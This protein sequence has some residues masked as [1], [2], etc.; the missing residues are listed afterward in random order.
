MGSRDTPCHA[1][2]GFGTEL[3]ER[4]VPCLP[5]EVILVG[6][7]PRNRFGSW[8]RGGLAAGGM[9]ATAAGSGLLLLT[10]LR[11]VGILGGTA[12]PHSEHCFSGE[13]HLPEKSQGKQGE[14]CCTMHT[15]MQRV[16]TGARTHTHAAHAQV[17]TEADRA[18]Q[19]CTHGC[20]LW[21]LRMELALWGRRLCQLSCSSSYGKCWGWCCHT[22]VLLCGSIN[23]W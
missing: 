16:C 20:R 11:A 17:R 2:F 9:G 5:L 12:A 1:E 15:G 23:R 21:M 3:W 14:S 18:V 6:P 8:G 10:L 19:M 4:Q 22:Q 13:N 7:S